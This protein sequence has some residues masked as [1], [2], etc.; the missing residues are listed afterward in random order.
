MKV[1]VLRPLAITVLA[2]YAGLAVL[3][4]AAIASE[5]NGNFLVT[6][7]VLAAPL[8]A[9]GIYACGILQPKGRRG[10]LTR[11]SG[12]LAMLAGSIPLISFSFVIWPGLLL[13]LPY[14]V[15]RE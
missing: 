4:L 8:A 12:W 6:V 5:G 1:Y 7:A 11:I 10:Q 15:S 2:A 13:A 9:A 14:T 3:L